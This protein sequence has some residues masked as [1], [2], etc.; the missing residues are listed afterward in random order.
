MS[1]AQPQARGACCRR[2][3]RETPAKAPGG[4][5]SRSTTAAAI[6]R[7][8]SRAPVHL[9]AATARQ[10]ETAEEEAAAGGSESTH[11]PVRSRQ[12]KL[13]ILSTGEVAAK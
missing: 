12:T 3:V 6:A 9:Q 8:A 11:A 4:S 13:A 1:E 5:T 7:R 2:P 10:V